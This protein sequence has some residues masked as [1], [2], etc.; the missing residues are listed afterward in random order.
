MFVYRKQRS[1]PISVLTANVSYTGFYWL[2]QLRRV[3]RS[4]DTDSAATLVHAFV[5]WRV[6]YRNILLASAQKVVTDKL[7]RVLN[8]AAR[9]V[10]STYKYDRGLLR[11][12]H[13]E[14]HWLDVPER[15]HTNF[16]SQCTVACTAN[17]LGTSQ[18]S[19]YQCPT[20][21]HGSIFDRYSASLGGAAMPAH[22]TRSTGILCGRLV[23]FELST[24]RL[25]RY[26]SWK[27]PLQTSAEDAF[28]YTELKHLAY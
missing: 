20:S 11:L 6:D 9:V 2:R 7:Q 1:H 8:T 21:Q 10:S 5:C 3:R 22:H 25:E 12:L 13:S 17:D 15:L 24:R 28:I 26:E 14:L 18:I 4:L 19:V 16:A 23:A 27:G